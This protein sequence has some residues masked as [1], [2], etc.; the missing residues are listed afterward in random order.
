MTDPEGKDPAI[1][2]QWLEL[3]SGINDDRY[4]IN[5][6]YSSGERN[7]THLYDK[8]TYLSLWT[9]Y[10]LNSSHMG[11]LD[12]PGSWS[13][14]P[15]IDSQ[16]QADLRSKS[17]DT[18]DNGLAYSRGHM[19]PNGS[20]NGN[21]GMQKQTFHVTNSVPQR[22]DKFNGS[23][24]AKLETAVQAEASSEE[25]YVVT[26]VALNKV[27]ENKTIHYVSPKNSSQDCAIPN[28]FYKLV[29]KVKYTGRTVTSASTIGFWFVHQDYS[30]SDY[31]KYAVSVDQVEQW[32]G[33]DF[34]VNVPDSVENA[35]ESNTSWTA[36]Q[37]F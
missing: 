31:T 27:G 20:R 8:D 2:E 35:A 19:I 7:Y 22:Q 9:A 24:W 14:N 18:G 34:F 32:T 12:R 15:N 28:Y 37:N 17:Y 36:F 1:D 6:M 10:P 23:I 33:F 13:Y 21:S 25:I 4:I 30:D 11:S 5:T 26:G 3:P 29:L 16:Y